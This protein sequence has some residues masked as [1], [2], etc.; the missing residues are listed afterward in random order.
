M[1]ARVVG[2]QNVVARVSV[3]LDTEAVSAVEDKYDPNGQVV[4]SQ[5]SND[6]TNRTVEVK[7]APVATPANENANA[8]NGAPANA[9]NAANGANQLAN[10][11]PPH[12]TTEGIRK[13]KSVNY[14][15]NHSRTETVKAPGN[16]RRISAAVFIAQRFTEQDGKRVAQ[17]RSAEEIE[18]IR[19]MI[20]QAIG[21]EE[22][23]GTNGRY[24]T[25]EET[26][27]AP[28]VNPADEMKPDMT[29]KIFNWIDM[30]KNF[31]AVGFAA[32]M[33]LI[34][35]RL[36]K[37]HK[38]EPYTLEIMDEE[39]SDNKKGADVVPRLTPELLNELIREK[40]ENVSTALRN[41]ALETNNKK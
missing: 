30:M 9:A 6:E 5:T 4:R 18:Q 7:T 19:Q 23:T 26:D 3:E 34:F 21:V 16:V 36:I 8:A 39:T 15:I 24:V 27:F 40:P 14:E 10:A 32:V 41:W 13:N 25:L 2:Q 38:P 31:I 29:Q 33:F 12:N 37:K 20:V 17:P 35:L 1:L 22:G 28:T 11:E